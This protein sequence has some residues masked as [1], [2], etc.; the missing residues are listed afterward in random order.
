MDALLREFSD[1]LGPV[2]TYTEQTL[3]A[4]DMAEQPHVQHPALS[5]WVLCVSDRKSVV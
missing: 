5:E 2:E 1:I 3:S 4:E